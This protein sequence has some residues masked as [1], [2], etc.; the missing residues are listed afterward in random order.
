MQRPTVLLALAEEADRYA[1]AL[2]AAG[3]HPVQELPS[4]G[5]RADLAVI[6]CD[7]PPQRAEELYSALHGDTPV[8]TLM[9]FGEVIPEFTTGVTARGQDEYAVKP[10]PPESLVYRL[11]ALLIRE[12]RRLPGEDGSMDGAAEGSIIGEGEVISVFAPKGG[13]G[14]TTVA[15]NTAV[16]LRQQTR[17]QVLL[18]D[19]D[20]GVGNV[21]SVLAAPY[22]MGLADLADTPPE[23]WTDA[24]FEQ[25]TTVHDE[26]GTRVLTWGVDPGQ[27]ERV[28]VDLLLAAVRWARTHH[29]YVIIDNHPGYADRT[30]AMLT[31]STQI[32]LV[33]TPEVGPLRNSSQ[34]LELARELGLRDTVRVVVNR[35]NHG[36]RLP[37]IEQ[38]LKMP[39]SATI[40][41]NGPK[42]V[43]AS[44]EG[45]PIITRFPR[46]RIANDLHAVAR[47]VTGAGHG[48]Y[49]VAGRRRNWLSS[50]V[51]RTSGA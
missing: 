51:S 5:A 10:V 42:A 1:E 16:A 2:T 30:M 11:Q 17:S 3:F 46:E 33:V 9:V 43:V 4:D 50:L 23:E 45:A 29:S 35:A 49:T 15:V 31:V 40:I 21:T 41:S 7:L 36:V 25:A 22:R 39:V 47:V 20:V 8:P 19:A 18:F 12:G 48:P 37:D 34:F 28:T 44:N 38:A 26:S 24:A 32:L 13:V 6:D 27:S 14:K